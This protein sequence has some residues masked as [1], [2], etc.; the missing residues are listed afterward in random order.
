MRTLVVLLVLTVGFALCFSGPSEA[1]VLG[2]FCFTIPPFTDVLKLSFITD[3]GGNTGAVTGRDVSIN[4]A[5]T[6]GAVLESDGITVNMVATVGAPTL[7]ISA[8]L[9]QVRLSRLT[10]AGSGRCQTVNATSGG[11]G[12]GTN[13]SF[14]PVGCPVGAQAEVQAIGHLA[15]G[16]D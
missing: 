4:T 8:Y 3:D 1:A 7:G 12:F 5:V 2:P 16:G 9:L 10:S 15:G 13:I 6:G 14:L 11:C